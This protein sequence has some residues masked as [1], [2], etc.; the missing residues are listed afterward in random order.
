MDKQ[1]LD[2]ITQ[3]IV[4]YRVMITWIEQK[5]EKHHAA[6]L[7]RQYPR[8]KS[9]HETPCTKTLEESDVSIQDY[10]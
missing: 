5:R 10:R 4:I 8:T 2:I 9:K 1:Q 3:G 7:D 6:Y